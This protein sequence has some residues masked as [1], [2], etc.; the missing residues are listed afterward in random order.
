MVEALLSPV[1]LSRKILLT[2]ALLYGALFALL[3]PTRLGDPLDLTFS[4]DA[5]E[6]NAGAVHLLSSLMYSLDGMTPS[7]EREPGMSA[8]LAFVYFFFGLENRLAVFVVQGVLYLLAV[9]AFVHQ[10]DRHFTPR[11][12][13]IACFLLLFL[14]PAFHAQLSVYREGL[15]L[16]LFLLFSSA[17]L[18]LLRQRS[19]RTAVAAGL[20]LGALILTYIPF[21]FLPLFIFPLLLLWKV[22]R[23]CIGTV[24]LL[25]V[26]IV[27]FWGARNF[28]EDGRFRMTGNFRTTAMLY[29]R[30]EQAEHLRGLKPF[31][32]LLAEYVTRDWSALPLTCS[33][34]YLIN[35]RWPGRIPTGEEATIA[36]ESAQKLFSFFPHYLWFSLFEILELHLPFV[37]GWG[38]LYNILTTFSTILLYLGCALAFPEILK[39]EHAIFLFFILYS[40]LVFALTDA[41]P[42]YLVPTLFAYAALA[43]IGYSRVLP[44]LGL[45]RMSPSSSR[46]TM[47]KK[48]SR[49]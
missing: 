2:G 41:T 6:Y 40:T 19:L 5:S 37:D 16:S 48:A 27:L 46:P 26:G 22:R 42:R 17:L 33:T 38:R 18:A 28:L 45:C 9:M 7:V 11:V 3:L 31:R 13:H 47:R 20:L 30:G 24:L 49:R 39:R 14:P 29:A 43:S 8:F 4:S 32:C 36:R 21:L 35:T 25:S 1:M 34:N 12:A 23:Q 10:L 44:R 15:A